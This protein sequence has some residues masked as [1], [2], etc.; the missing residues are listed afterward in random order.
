MGDRNNKKRCYVLMGIGKKTDFETGRTLD[1]DLVY[2]EVIKPAVEEEG[3]ECLRSDEIVH[4]GLIDIPVHD[5]LLNADVVIADI[6]T[7]N[8]NAIYELGLRHALRP[9]GTIV[10]SEEG[11]YSFPFDLS[12]V[13]IQKYLHLGE[14]IALSEVK[15]FKKI[16][17]GTIRAAL[18]NLE[19]ENPVPDS[20]LYRYL[21][22]LQP[23]RLNADSNDAVGTIKEVEVG[24]SEHTSLAILIELG[25]QAIK[26]GQF[27]EALNNYEVASNL[28]P[29]NSYLVQ[30]LVFVTYRANQPDT[31]T[32]LVK[33]R[34]M[35]ESL[36]PTNSND[37]QTL[38]LFGEIE[39][40]LFETKR[41]VNHLLNSRRAYERLYAIKRDWQSGI[42]LAYLVIQ[43]SELRKEAR[44][45][46]ADI[47][48]AQRL[49]REVVDLGNARLAEINALRKVQSY[50]PNA[51]SEIESSAEEMRV[52]CAI[53]EAYF[54]LGE[55]DSY[56]DAH[57][58]ATMKKGE[59]DGE[60]LIG[61]DSRI[62]RL[63]ILLKNGSD[64]PSTLVVPGQAGA[65]NISDRVAP[66]E[67]VQSA[68]KGRNVSARDVVFFSYS[69]EDTRWLDEIK[70]TLS[71]AFRGQKIALWD[72]SKIKSGE[73]WKEKIE[74]ALS[75]AR[76]AVLI[77]SRS[78]LASEFIAND[79]LPYILENA[80]TN[81]V[82]P[83]WVCIEDCLY[84]GTGLENYQCLN[85]P[86]MPLTSLSPE[87]QNRQIVAVCRD[88][89]SRMLAS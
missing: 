53:A 40:A 42:T 84:E 62:Q 56:Q 82:I 51:P 54:I 26:E 21:K 70:T 20:P 18:D 60:T 27:G 74:E 49:C 59:G 8:R 36:V 81:G 19:H 15:R 37:P 12:I 55:T 69:H 48:V 65:T 35:L 46:D 58:Y 88:I 32:A 43:H 28:D 14:D 30:R 63:S 4:S 24:E 47:V 78:F 79:E 1:L 23:P 33:A 9:Y 76:A 68:I 13:E 6:S 44:E 77:V 64:F 66:T 17:R 29:N 2:R 75:R 7:F 52:Y 85:D 86:K 67:K 25:E 3:L 10:I 16:L 50:L 57:D 22:N 61:L 45:R 38:S 71:P 83:L 89:R 31:V 11:M 41:S 5:Q 80:E 72:D 87:E 39:Q 73:R 34:R